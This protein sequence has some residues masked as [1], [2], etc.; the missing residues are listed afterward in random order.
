MSGPFKKEDIAASLIASF[1]FNVVTSAHTLAVLHNM[2]GIFFT[3]GVFEHPYMRGVME[4][5]TLQRLC[6]HQGKVGQIL[7]DR[8]SGG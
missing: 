5:F 6:L 2:K 1:C 4:K 3:G 7:C 8:I